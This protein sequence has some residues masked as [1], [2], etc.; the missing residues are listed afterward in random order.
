MNPFWSKLNFQNKLHNDNCKWITLWLW[1]SNS[2]VNKNIY[3]TSIQKFSN[4]QLDTSPPPPSP[5]SLL[6]ISRR[7]GQGSFS[8]NTNV[9]K[10]FGITNFRLT[11]FNDFV[12]FFL[13]SICIWIFQTNGFFCLLCCF[14]S[15]F[16]FQLYEWL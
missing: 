2:K 1:F 14:M 11:L 16:S 12:L 4:A 13:T 6:S 10:S 8:I 15:E 7:K 5:I 9:I 3:Q